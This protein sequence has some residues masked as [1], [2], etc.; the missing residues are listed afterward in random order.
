MGKGVKG[1]KKTASAGM[2][3]GE[4]VE[5]SP[6]D[7]RRNQCQFETFAMKVICGERS[8][9]FRELSALSAKETTFSELPDIVLNNLASP[10][11]D[12]SEQYVF[13]IL[14]YYVP[15]Q[16]DRLVESL[17]TFGDIE[18]TI[19]LLYYSLDF[20]D[21]EIA[22]LLGLSRSKIQKERTELLKELRR[23]MGG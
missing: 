18:Y 2:E 3:G 12:P 5:F 14:G 9:Y 8:D 15:I 1:G 22:S 7:Q 20:K 17:L 19:L 6:S 16:N 23:K 21:R 4:T 13:Q 10:G 11:S